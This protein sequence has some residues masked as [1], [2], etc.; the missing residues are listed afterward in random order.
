MKPVEIGNG[1][2]RLLIYEA[3]GAQVFQLRIIS[4]ARNAGTA[5]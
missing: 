2:C 1:R 5:F 4:D 3:D